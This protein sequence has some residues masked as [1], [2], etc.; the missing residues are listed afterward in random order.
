MLNRKRFRNMFP[1][2]GLRP[3]S[4][5]GRGPL[6]L[7][8]LWP[9]GALIAAFLNHHRALVHE[10][11]ETAAIVC[12]SRVDIPTRVGVDAVNGVELSGLF[13]ARA[14][15]REDLERCAVNDPY[16]LVVAV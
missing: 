1:S 16:L 9:D 6:L 11:L 15:A 4:P 2:P 8:C 5:V 10:A 13:A 12:L 7:S 3:P 14:E